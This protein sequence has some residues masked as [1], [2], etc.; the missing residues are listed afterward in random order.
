MILHCFERYTQK[1]LLP[2]GWAAAHPYC[3]AEPVPNLHMRQPSPQDTHD[4]SKSRACSPRVKDVQA[5]R[6]RGSFMGGGDADAL[7][8][9]SLLI[10]V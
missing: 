9:C 5:N 8:A 4:G 1:G 2:W 3:M 10:F 7:S 6:V